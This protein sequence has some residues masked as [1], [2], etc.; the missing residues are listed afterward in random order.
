[1]KAGAAAKGK[2]AYPGPLDDLEQC[3]PDAAQYKQAYR[4]L[5]SLVSPTQ[6]Q[7]PMC[8]TI[9]DC[10]FVSSADSTD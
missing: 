5:T 10:E 3:L 2:F 9:L 6:E 4:L 7:R 1:M 8:D